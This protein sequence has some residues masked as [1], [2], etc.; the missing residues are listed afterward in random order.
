MRASFAL[1]TLLK[2]G[3][4][5][6]ITLRHG[7]HHIADSAYPVASLE[8]EQ[9]AIQRGLTF[10]LL[11]QTE[12]QL[13]QAG[14]RWET[15][16]LRFPEDGTGA[17][18]MLRNVIINDAK[19]STYK[20]ALLRTLVR[21]ADSASGLAK[22]TSDEHVSVP[23]G[24]VALYW[25][26]IYK[27]LIENSIPQMPANIAHK[28]LAFVGNAFRQLAN[29]SPFE[30]RVGEV[31]H[32]TTALALVQAI[33]DA[34]QTIRKMPAYYITYPNSSEQIF[35]VTG[36]I[37]LASKAD[38]NLIIDEEFLWS[39]GEMQVPTNLWRAFSSFAAWLEPALLF[40]WSEL[41]KQYSE[42]HGKAVDFNGLMT[43]LKWLDPA[44]D[45]GLVRGLVLQMMAQE[46]AAGAVCLVGEGAE[47]G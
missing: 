13:N 8:L 25:I 32:G 45:T 35:K 40:E 26:R 36:K 24:L 11:A 22:I 29:V 17:L 27:P 19:S 34:A 10:T 1:T 6:A 44:H 16:L 5:I 42:S 38:S 14:V 9:L 46:F 3:G 47:S 15:V 21:V 20:L 23:L 12:D 28:S 41:M 18:P 33:K 37:K 4:S 2:P 31:F 43:H 30:L 39:F 7:E